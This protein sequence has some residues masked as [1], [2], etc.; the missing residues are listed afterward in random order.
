MHKGLNRCPF[1]PDFQPV[2]TRRM[3]R[4]DRTVAA[5]QHERGACRD[6]LRAS[7]RLFRLKPGKSAAQPGGHQF[8]PPVPSGRDKEGACTHHCREA[9]L[10][11]GMMKTWKGFIDIRQTC[12]LYHIWSAEFVSVLF[13]LCQYCANISGEGGKRKDRIDSLE[14]FMLG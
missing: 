11:P 2:P 14:G 13:F 9:T 4:R 5:T 1:R 12:I 7:F 6:F 3:F 10:A 8:G